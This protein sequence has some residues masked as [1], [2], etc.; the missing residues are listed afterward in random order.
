MW[1]YGYFGRQLG[2]YVLTKLPEA[3]NYEYIYKNDELLVKVDQYG[4]VT[5]QINPPIGEAVYK[6]EEREVGSPIKVSVFDGKQMHNNFDVLAADE[7]KIEFEPRKAAYSLLFGQMRLITEII[8]PTCGKMFLM[9]IT[10]E[11]RSEENKEYKILSS[12]FPYLNELLMAPWDKPEWYTKTEYL[13]KEKAFLTTKYSV[14]GK[15]EERKY[16]IATGN[17]DIVGHEL[18]LERLLFITKNFREMPLKIGKGIKEMVYAFKQCAAGFSKISLAP[19]ANCTFTQVYGVADKEEDVPLVLARAKEY[20]DGRKQE[21]ELKKLKEKYDDL[22]AIRKIHTSDSS[23]DHFVNGFLPLEMYW[24]SSLDRGWPTGMRGVRDASNDFEGMLCYD[25]KMCKD[26]IENIFSKQRNDGW[27]PRQ[28]P[29]G[30]SKKFDLREFVDAAAFFTE[31]VYDYL[32]Y[33]DDFSILDKTYPYYDDET[34]ATGLEHLR[35]GLDHLLLPSSIGKHGLIKMKGGDWLDCLSGA[36]KEG[37]GESVMVSCQLVMCLGYLKEILERI[38]KG[39]YAKKYVEAADKLKKAI[40]ESAFNGRFYNAVYTDRGKWLFSDRDEDGQKRVYVPTNAYAVISGVSKGKEDS[41]FAEIKELRTSEGYKLFSVPLGATCIEGIGKMG[42]GDFQPYFA[43]NGSVYNHGS[44]CFLVRAMAKDGRFAEIFDV[45][46]F[47]M[48]FDQERHE[49]AKTC[50]APYAVTNC[51]HLVPSFYGRAGFS[52]LTG[53]VA[54]IERAVYSWVFGVN[55]TLAEMVISPCLPKEYADAEIEIP[56]HAHRIKIKYI[57]YGSTIDRA[58]IDDKPLSISND[59]RSI[60]I[61]KAAIDRDITI[62]VVLNPK[63]I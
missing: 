28:V 48:P 57:G 15:K 3:G 19:N 13:E 27:Y 5:A 4:L 51:Y 23:F 47:A 62:L 42:T 60:S 9:N 16:L 12:S 29:F 59:G 37:L 17:E 58:L 36:G 40:N 55:F 1:E 6:R 41:I 11:N 49:P 50:A 53:S 34:E 43:E 18:S 45:L 52:F 61:P 46:N 31:Y 56:Y 25:P 44:Q 35:K 10:I 21:A 22:F 14:A 2:S 63:V 7:I 20:F 30:D 8:V 32:S 54:M 39:S 33:T 24:V 38:G 26:V